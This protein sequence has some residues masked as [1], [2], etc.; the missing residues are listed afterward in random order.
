STSLST[1]HLA[2]STNN[3]NGAATSI[4]GDVLRH[5][6]LHREPLFA[7]LQSLDPDADALLC[8]SRA[9]KQVLDASD[10]LWLNRH[11][12]EAA[13]RDHAGQACFPRLDSG[14][15]GLL[16]S[17]VGK[18]IEVQGQRRAGGLIRTAM[19]ATDILMDRV[20]Q[21]ETDTFQG[22]PGFVFAPM[23]EVVSP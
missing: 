5:Y 15:G 21:L 3:N 16:V 12:L 14:L 23:T 4:L 13:Y 19:R 8:A 17:D 6:Q 18:P 9:G 10:Q 7:N 1:Q 11:L 2:L 20:W 22:T